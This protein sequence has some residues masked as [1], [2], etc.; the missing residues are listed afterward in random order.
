VHGCDTYTNF[1]GVQLQVLANQHPILHREP[2]LLKQHSD[3][4]AISKIKEGLA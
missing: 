1:A 4:M 3:V 2:P